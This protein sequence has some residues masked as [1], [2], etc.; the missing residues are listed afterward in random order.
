MSP[1]SVHVLVVARDPL[2]ETLRRLLSN[3]GFALEETGS[4]ACALDLIQALPRDL[5]LLDYDLL[6]TPAL[7]TCRTIRAVAPRTGIV[8]VHAGGQPGDDLLAL[9]AGADD[10]VAAP[11]R[12]REIVARLGAVLRRVRAPELPPGSAGILRAG[13]LEIDLRRRQF[14]R[15]GKPIHLSPREFD[16]LCFFMK[17]QGVVLTHTRL[18]NGVWGGDSARHTT[19]LRSYVKALRRKIEKDPAVPEYLITEPW[20]GYVFRN[21]SYPVQEPGFVDESA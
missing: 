21:P 5:V 7:E 14:W 13:K 12:F 9:E 6:G 11:F 17:H 19:Y 16:L 10:Y 15:D 3:T 8:V 18:L 4:A 20:V 1:E 2:R